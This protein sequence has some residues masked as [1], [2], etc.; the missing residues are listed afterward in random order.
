MPDF[1]EENR[2]EERKAE[3]AYMIPPSLT[4][5]SANLQ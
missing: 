4:S 5:S 1:V 2:R 3:L